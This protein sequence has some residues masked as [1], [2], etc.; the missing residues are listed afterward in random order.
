MCHVRR[1]DGSGHQKDAGGDQ[2]P[3]PGPASSADRGGADGPAFGDLSENYEYKCAKQAKSRNDSRIR[4][5]ER[6][7]RLP[8]SSR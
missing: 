2:L 6:M 4:Y 5:L 7:I 8:R 3:D 1:T